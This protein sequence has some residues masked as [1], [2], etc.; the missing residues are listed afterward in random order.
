[1]ENHSVY[2]PLSVFIDVFEMILDMF[3]EGVFPDS[4]DVAIREEEDGYSISLRGYK[5]AGTTTTTK[6]S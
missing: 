1:M 6:D 5:R 3:D 2:I 4:C